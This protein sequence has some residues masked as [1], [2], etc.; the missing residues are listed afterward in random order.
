MLF[1]V[2]LRNAYCGNVKRF[3]VN[4]CHE[5]HA[6]ELAETETEMLGDKGEW[7]VYTVLEQDDQAYTDARCSR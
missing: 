1:T 3:E 2:T 4:A 6:R 7:H 5:L